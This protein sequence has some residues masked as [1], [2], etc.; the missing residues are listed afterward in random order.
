MSQ[1]NNEQDNQFPKKYKKLLN[2]EFT[3]NA[4]G[5]SEE[6]LKKTILTCEGNLYTIEKEK[7]NDAKLNAALSLAK[8]YKM[9]YVEAEKYQKAKIQY[10][11]FLL[12]NKGVMM[13]SEE[14]E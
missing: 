7:E 14:K 8:D 5:L 3:D 9:P 4:D 12:E 10:C 11:L 2:P 1:E 13:N 6:D